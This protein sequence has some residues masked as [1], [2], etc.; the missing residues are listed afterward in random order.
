M[1]DE[2]RAEGGKGKEAEGDTEVWEEWRQGLIKK[3]KR[4]GF[5][6]GSVV[7]NSPA[8][9]QDTGLIPGLGRFYMLKGN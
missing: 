8:S 2:Q 3:G 5:S 7:K 4:G 9:A 1:S 6:G